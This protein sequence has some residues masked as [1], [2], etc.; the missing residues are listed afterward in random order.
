MVMSGKRW[1][2]AGATAGFVTAAGLAA[3]AP[4]MAQESSQ[5][6]VVH[7]IP[8]QPVDVYVDGELTLEDFQPGEIAGPL[9][10]PS[11]SYDIDLTAPGDPVGNAILSADGVEV[12]GGANLSVVA[13]LSEGGE[14]TLTAYANDVSALPAGQ[15]RVTARHTAAAPAVDVRVEGEP[16]FTGLTNPDEATAEVAAGTVSVDVVLA[17]TGTVVLG[18]AD[19]DLREGSHTIAYAIGSADD[20]TLEL[21]VQ[22]IDGVHAAPDGVPAGTA[23]LAGSGAATW[24][25]VLAAG[26]V[27]LLAGGLARL[28]WTGGAV[29]R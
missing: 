20:E 9:E 25:F 1:L 18:P 8:G 29:R 10:L 6:A 27:L 14:P 13:H 23:G 17:G 2:L 15:A 11:G 21:V 19:L 24:W 12:P 3:A 5:V 7:G 16:V 28:A 26:G 4:A 22:V